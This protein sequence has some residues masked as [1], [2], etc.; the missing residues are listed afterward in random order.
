MIDAG[1]GVALTTTLKERSPQP[2]MTSGTTK[3]V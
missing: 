3:F 2:V 1:L